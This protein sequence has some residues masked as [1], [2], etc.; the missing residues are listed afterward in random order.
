MIR[1]WSIS[2]QSGQS[3][4]S[5]LASLTTF[6][7]DWLAGSDVRKPAERGSQSRGSEQWFSRAWRR[8]EPACASL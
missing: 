8:T 4:G 1:Y 6:C 3:V 7:S 2:P 5:V